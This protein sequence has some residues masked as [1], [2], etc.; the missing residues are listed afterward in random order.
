MKLKL[1]V[2]VEDNATVKRDPNLVHTAR[3]AKKIAFIGNVSHLDCL[4]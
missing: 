3:H 1:L 2:I 4:N